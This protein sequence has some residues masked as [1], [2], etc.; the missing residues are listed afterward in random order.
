MSEYQV[1]KV[2]DQWRLFDATITCVKASENHV[3]L[4]KGNGTSLHFTLAEFN[5]WLSI[6]PVV[7]V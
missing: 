1:P 2:G 3:V 7:K 5:Q 6:K 4:R